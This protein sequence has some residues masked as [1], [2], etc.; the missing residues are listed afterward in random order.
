MEIGDGEE[1]GV[2]ANQEF[3]RALRDEVAELWRRGEDRMNRE[4]VEEIGQRFD[5]DRDKAREAFVKA[6]GDLW[7]G[8]FVESDEEPG[9]DAVML[10]SVPSSGPQEGNPL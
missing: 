10:E 5:V 6:R 7:K 1:A 4:H 2:S 9:W 3:L 8:E